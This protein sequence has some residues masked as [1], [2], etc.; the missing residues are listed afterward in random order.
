[1]DSNINDYR[2]RGERERERR[3][4]KEAEEIELGT[5]FLTARPEMP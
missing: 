1:M 4:E 5:V 2:E 3:G